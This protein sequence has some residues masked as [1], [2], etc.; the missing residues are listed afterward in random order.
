MHARPDAGAQNNSV[1]LSFLSLTSVSVG[2]SVSQFCMGNGMRVSPCLTGVLVHW[3]SP[4]A[5]VPQ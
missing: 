4:G 1:Q 2:L 3:L 5:Q